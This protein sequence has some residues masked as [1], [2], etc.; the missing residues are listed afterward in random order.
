MSQPDCSELQEAILT[1]ITTRPLSEGTLHVEVKPFTGVEWPP[2]SHQFKAELF[3][4]VPFLGDHALLEQAH[5]RVRE[6]FDQD[7]ILPEKF[8]AVQLQ[9]G[10]AFNEDHAE[11][12]RVR[13]LPVTVT[14][15]LYS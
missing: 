9:A 13:V 6:G 3:L 1:Y 12:G 4:S 14:V 5:A 8:R 10:E 2:D 11:L 15:E 7:A